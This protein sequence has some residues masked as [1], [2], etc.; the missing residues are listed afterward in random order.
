VLG[1]LG[2]VTQ[3]S[4]PT[5]ASPDCGCNGK[6]KSKTAPGLRGKFGVFADADEACAAAQEAFVQLQKKGVEARR[7]IETIVKTLAEKN[8]EEWGRLELDE[9]KIGRLDHKIEKLQIIKLVPGVDWLRPDARSGDHGITLE[10]YTP[11]GVVGAITPSTHSIPTLSGNIVNIVA[12]GNAA[13]FNAHPAAARCAASAVRAYNEAIYRET[14]IENIATIIEKPTMESFNALCKNELVR[15]LLVTGG[16][17]VVKAAMLSGKRAICAGPGNPPVY[18]DDTACMKRAA[19]GIIQGASYDNNLL[20]I[21]EKEVFALENI[22]DK[23]MSEME[24]NGAVRLNPAQ[25]DALTKAA[26]TFKPG[27]GGGCPH[28]SV[29][30][31]F[32]GKDPIVLAKAAGV[33]IPSGTQLLFAETDANHPFVIEEQMMPFLPIVRVKSLD[34]GVARSL[35][36]EHGYKHTSIIHSHDVEAMTAMGRALDT[37]LFIKNGPCMAGLGLGGEGY[38]SY[39]IATPTGEGVTNPKTFTRVRRCVMVDNLRIY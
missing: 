25:L 14:G 3:P 31:D 30:K 19:K 35:E 10:E 16:P 36:A 38:L 13:V 6:A 37:T 39:S 23:L 2:G 15:L 9:T 11:F 12:A 4:T 20:C 17:G 33:S 34:E 1:R 32:I 24:K 8:A 27:E 7:K 21:G 22:A 18:V 29:N 28:A 26:F 5:N